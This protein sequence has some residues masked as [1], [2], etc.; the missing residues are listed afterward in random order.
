MTETWD[1]VILVT[2]IF[3]SIL[4]NYC[5]FSMLEK[6]NKESESRMDQMKTE[7]TM[8]IDLMNFELHTRQDQQ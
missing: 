7:L 1:F 5:Q 2:M 4:L 8:R 3:V 6:L